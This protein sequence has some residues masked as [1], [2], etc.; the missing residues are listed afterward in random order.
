MSFSSSRFISEDIYNNKGSFVDEFTLGILH[1]ESE[2]C[3]ASGGRSA[4][5]AYT[6]GIIHITG[7]ILRNL[8]GF[9]G[10]SLPALDYLYLLT[11]YMIPLSWLLC[12]GE[13]IISYLAK[14]IKNPNYQLGSESDNHSDLVE[15]FPNKQCYHLFSIVSTMTYFTSTQIV[16]HRM[17]NYGEIICDE[18]LHEYV[19]YLY[20][21]YII[22][23]W[24]MGR[25]ITNTLHPYYEIVFGI[26]L[27]GLIWKQFVYG[28]W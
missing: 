22:D 8:Y 16:Y 14:K 20:L 11:Y 4:K 17:C 27:F 2:F 24:Y 6:I 21:I 12:R 10:Y 13:C 26:L 28:Q 3:V 23:T 18:N 19:V 7:V 9:V 1:N 5:L 25:F 15:L